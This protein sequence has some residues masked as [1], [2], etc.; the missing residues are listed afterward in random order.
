LVKRA[1]ERGTSD[2]GVK[3]RFPSHATAKANTNTVTI[4]VA[5]KGCRELATSGVFH[6]SSVLLGF[7]V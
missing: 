3:E 2:E 4:V 7:F 5:I 6:I 1:W